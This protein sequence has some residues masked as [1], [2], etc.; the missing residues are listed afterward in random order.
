MPF[1]FLDNTHI[2]V[3][4][5]DTS[6]TPPTTAMLVLNSDYT[7]TGAGVVGGGSISTT[8]APT[9]TQTLTILRNVPFT[10][11]VHYVPNDPFPAATHEQALD[12]LTMELQQL[13]EIAGH[14]I[15]FPTY[16]PLP[17]TLLPAAQRAGL[18]LGFDSNGNLTYIPLPASVGAGDLRNE[19]WTAGV[20]YTINSSTTVTLSRGYGSKG[21]LGTVVM[22]GVAQDPATYSLISNGTQ[23][24]FN[25]AIPAGRVWCIGGTTLSIFAPATKSVGD[26]Q[27]VDGRLLPW[28]DTTAT[29]HMVHSGAGTIPVFQT[30]FTESL[31][32]GAGVFVD[33]VVVNHTRTNGNGHRQAFTAQITSS[34]ANTGE[35]LV[36]SCGFGFLQSGSG[37]VSGMNAYAQVLA[38]AAATAEMVGFEANTD[39]QRSVVRKTGIQIVDVSTSTADASVISAGLYIVKQVGGAG[40]QNGIQFGDDSNPT[41]MA[42]TAVDLIRL[43]GSTGSVPLARGIDFRAGNFS[44]PAIDLPPNSALAFGGGAS[45]TIG[46]AGTVQSVTSTGGP[47]LQFGNQAVAIVDNALTA[48]A[49]SVL[50]TPGSQSVSVYMPGVG[51]RQLQ[52]GAA[53]S[54]GAGFRSVVCP[55]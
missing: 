30:D 49:F 28:S 13:N 5:T 15:T 41:G 31:S 39:A 42:P 35:F 23:L 21:N 43:A 40:W 45:G 36:G 22:D 11:L 37:N 2:K 1:Y 44:G 25:A 16:E 17:P 12:Q 9:A 7:A 6:T 14:A 34:G 54:G 48:Q 27:I 19:S 24:Q 3:L 33:G 10:Q 26:S 4:R 32:P 29:Y 55:N 46:S 53:N 20:D 52:V 51:L 50:T 47:V 18:M 38:A 8:V